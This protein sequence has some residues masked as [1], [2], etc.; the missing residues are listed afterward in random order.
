MHLHAVLQ[1]GAGQKGVDVLCVHRLAAQLDHHR[2]ASD[3][4]SAAGG[5]DRGL[6]RNDTGAN[7]GIQQ[8]VKSARGVVIVPLHHIA[9]CAGVWRGFRHLEP[10]DHVTRELAA[11]LA[12]AQLCIVK[13]VGE[14]LGPA[15]HIVEFDL[16][17]DHAGLE[18]GAHRAVLILSQGY[19]E[20]LAGT[21]LMAL[22]GKALRQLSHLDAMRRQHVDEVR[23]TTAIGRAE[24]IGANRIGIRH[25]PGFAKE[26]AHMALQFSAMV[27][28]RADQGDRRA[29]LLGDL[30]VI[31]LNP[32][33]GLLDDAAH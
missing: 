13:I 28:G 32:V 1:R 5:A 29:G 6:I 8:S 2:A 14:G 3:F 30:V 21:I 15:R 22:M 4:L 9:E 31:A 25:L 17:G 24:H 19:D 16:V 33:L 10:R 7:A 11:E 27:V 20:R 23:Q 26:F 18:E 12:A